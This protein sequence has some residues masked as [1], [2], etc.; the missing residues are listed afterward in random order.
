MHA[1]QTRPQGGALGM[2][3][4]AR[5]LSLDAMPSPLARQTAERVPGNMFDAR[6]RARRGSLRLSPSWTPA[7]ASP[8]WPR[9]AV[10]MG[11]AAP[12]AHGAPRPQDPAAIKAAVDAY[13]TSP[14]YERFVESLCRDALRAITD[15]V[16]RLGPEQ[17]RRAA[18]FFDVDDTLLSSHPDRRHRFA[19]WLLSTGQRMPAA[20]LPPLAPVV[21]LYNALRSMGVRTVILTGRRS[22]NEAVTLDNL[23]WAGVD[24]WD[25]AIFRTVGTPEQHVDA[26]E[27]KSRQRARLVAAGYVPVANIGDQHSD[28][29]G[30]NSGVAVKLPNP[31]HTIP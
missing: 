18:A 27:Y 15:V 5:R 7:P 21:N 28:L 11:L 20:Y 13:M 8:S 4:R 9:A 19:T 30:G 23:R 6:P 22:T 2:P 26:V 17:R 12:A 14:T 29:N 24:G 1:L 31:M 3:T 10:P 16:H 25:H